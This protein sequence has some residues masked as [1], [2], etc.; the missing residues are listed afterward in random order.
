MNNDNYL[1]IIQDFET[2]KFL[3]AKEG[4]ENVQILLADKIL[5]RSLQTIAGKASL[6]AM[7]INSLKDVA[8]I[9]A[10][11]DVIS[12]YL[13][14]NFADNIKQFGALSMC[15]ETVKHLCCNS[16]R[17]VIQL[18]LLKHL[19]HH[20]GIDAVK[21]SCKTKEL[22]WILPQMLEVSTA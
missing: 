8:G 19:V 10:A 16:G 3:K 21:E 11:L 5:K 20:R 15:L 2:V 1:I 6:N 22:N 12:K 13:D 4:G 14:K 7:D 9:R 18:F 17:S